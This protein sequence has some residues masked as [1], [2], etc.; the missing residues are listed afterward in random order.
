MTQFMQQ[1]VTRKQD[2]IQIDG[3]NGITW[4]PAE[5]V[6]Q[7]GLLVGESTD[8]YEIVS[9]Y[10]DYYEGEIDYVGVVTGYGAR[11]SAPG[12]M[13]CTE[14]TVFDTAQEAQEYLDENYPEDEEEE[15]A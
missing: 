15:T 8:D 3:S 9:K 12:Y 2:W 5:D 14:W 7:S 13:D 11:L 1:Q 6:A 4:I 10:E